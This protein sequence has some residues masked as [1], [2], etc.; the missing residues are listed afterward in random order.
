MKKILFI[1]FTLFSV[2]IF[3]GCSK[4]TGCT[5][6]T[7]SNYSSSAEVDDNSC[8]YSTKIEFTVLNSLGNKASNATVSLYKNLS[9]LTN[10]INAV[11][12]KITDES[13][14]VLFDNLEP[15]KYYFY[16]ELDC[17]NNLNSANMF[18]QPIIQGITNRANIL[19]TE[20]ESTIHVSSYYNESYK[21]Y[22]NDVYEGTISAMGDKYI[23]VESG[24]YTIKLEQV[25]YVFYP[26]VYT[27][28]TTVSCGDEITLNFQ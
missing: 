27:Q 20:S 4:E 11:Q 10:E 25:D 5:D 12:T 3:N 8:V 6:S 18:V 1:G 24:S 15:L 13:G 14:I 22:V 23:T 9:D 17:E 28:S 2:L 16:A 19:L 26:D 7:A 21:V